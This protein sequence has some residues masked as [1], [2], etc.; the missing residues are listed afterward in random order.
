MVAR[1]PDGLLSLLDACRHLGRGYLTRLA[2]G[3]RSFRHRWPLL[4]RA[5]AADGGEAKS[6][7]IE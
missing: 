3:A 1:G 4:V 2:I 5:S 7:A 6:K